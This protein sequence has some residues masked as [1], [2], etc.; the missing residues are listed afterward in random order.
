MSLF[1][2]EEESDED[3]D[4]TEDDT[5]RDF[6]NWLYLTHF[7]DETRVNL[8][9]RG[10]LFVF[11]TT[12]VPLL[13]SEVVSRVTWSRY[14]SNTEMSIPL[15]IIKMLLKKE[16]DLFVTSFTVTSIGSQKVQFTIKLPVKI[17]KSLC[18]LIAI[19]CKTTGIFQSGNFQSDRIDKTE[20]FIETF[21]EVF[22][23]NLGPAGRNQRGFY[24]KITEQLASAIYCTFTGEERPESADVTTKII[25]AISKLEEDMILEFLNTWFTF[26]RI[27]RFEDEN[28]R[29]M[30]MFRD[31]EE[32]RELV[33]LLDIV[34]VEWETG[35]LTEGEKFIPTYIVKNTLEN[36]AILNLPFINT[37]QTKRA[38]LEEISTLKI[39]VSMKDEKIKVLEKLIEQLEGKLERAKEKKK[40]VTYSRYYY[41]KQAEEY[42]TKYEEL[43]RLKR[44]LEEENYGIKRLLV[45]GKTSDEKTIK[46]F[47][48]FGYKS[49]DKPF[50]DVIEEL[51]SFKGFNA[52]QKREYIIREEIQVDAAREE[53]YTTSSPSSGSTTPDSHP[54]SLS[55]PSMTKSLLKVMLTLLGMPENWVLFCLSESQPKT[56][57]ELKNFLDIDNKFELR[58]TITKYEGLDI[59]KVSENAKGEEV[60]TLNWEHVVRVVDK[61]R[62]KL[63]RTENPAS[64]KSYVKHVIPR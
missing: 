59:I 3:W 37:E 16:S 56:L 47:E 8:T 30:F 31:K 49:G 10:R 41:E 36:K 53:V 13:C 52:T 32:T 7:P 61:Y 11:Q 48:S 14:R 39:K 63:T 50:A 22:G 6:Q 4:E 57:D 21:E 17:D 25:S 9:K 45:E 44:E 1:Q 26:S 54:S 19:M 2:E 58:K 15:S 35:S 34:G 43:S 29:A 62:A 64:I 38:L 24:I 20:A 55:S 28:H 27:Y 40:Q 12:N 33:K 51:K 60:Y 5:S 18:R 46:A 42:K 23:V